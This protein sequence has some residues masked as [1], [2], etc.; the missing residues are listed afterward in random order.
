MQTI[1]GINILTFS[2][3]LALIIFNIVIWFAINKYNWFKPKKS[4][5]VLDSL[6]GLLNREDFL[7][8]S[9]H[10]LDKNK[11]S[12]FLIVFLDIDFFKSI[13][14]TYGH[15][16]G[17][18]VLINF[19]KIISSS[20]R[21]GNILAR[22][23][24][25]EFVLLIKDINGDNAHSAISR[26]SKSLEF[27]LKMD[28]NNIGV[29]SSIGVSQYPRDAMCL[30]QLLNYAD[31]AMYE[32]KQTGRNTFSF[33]SEELRLAQ[34][35]MDEN[36]KSLREILANK[37]M[38]G[39][40]YLSYQPLLSGQNASQD[41]KECEALLRWR[42]DEGNNIPPSEF[43]VQAEK[44]S[45]I[46]DINKFVIDEVCMQQQIWKE[47]GSL[48]EIRVN[49]NL[50]GSK[51]IF[52]E[53]LNR[54]KNNIRNYDLNPRLFGVEITERTLFEICDTTIFEL[55]S[56]RE[57]GMKISID[58]FGTGYSSFGYLN[59]LPITTLKIDKTFIDDLPNNAYTQKIVDSM[60]ALGH[61]LGLEIVAEGVETRE[62]L[63]Y[64]RSKSCDYIQGYLFKK[65]L[66]GFE[67]RNYLAH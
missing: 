7:K 12:E 53:L 14:D 23:G 65:P 35:S 8:Q 4:K 25:D 58:D 46:N 54:L 61:S 41:F 66:S 62:Q 49:I 33:Y 29:T 5:V 37:N 34:L 30:E 64:L 3:M 42:D 43:I 47:E 19:A 16:S 67:I 48:E 24:G 15:K 11:D 17:D 52:K 6:T 50:S 38:K 27:S 20:L 59:K 10:H 28:G 36:T 57:M 22:F 31:Q 9:A 32:S 21:E 13:N 39:N 63:M 44:S 40:L 51:E 2:I 26:L 60:I 56:I 18:R 45:L 55:A 1:F